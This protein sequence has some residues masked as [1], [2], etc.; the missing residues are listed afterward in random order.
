M[1]FQAGLLL[2]TEYLFYWTMELPLLVFSSEIFYSRS[3]KSV[4]M[5]LADKL[6]CRS[7]LTKL[8]RGYENSL[9]TAC[10]AIIDVQGKRSVNAGQMDFVPVV[11]V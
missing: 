6:A 4:A 7:Q 2:I 8:N 10:L 11:V 3:C 1:T 9:L 5:P